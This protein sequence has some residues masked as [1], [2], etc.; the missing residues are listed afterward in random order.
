[1]QPADQENLLAGNEGRQAEGRWWNRI[2]RPRLMAEFSPILFGI[3][4]GALIVSVGTMVLIVYSIIHIMLRWISFVKFTVHRYLS[5]TTRQFYSWIDQYCPEEIAEVVEAI[6]AATSREEKMVTLRERVLAMLADAWPS[7]LIMDWKDILLLIVLGTAGL[8]FTWM[9]YGVVFSSGKRVIQRLRGIDFEAVRPGSTFSAGS[10]PAFQVQIK[11][12]GTFTDTH[13][14]FGVRIGDY[15]VTP[16]HVVEGLD[17]A[18]FATPKA[19]LLRRIVLIKS[20]IFSD[21]VFIYLGPDAVSMLGLKNAKSVQDKTFVSTFATCY[22]TQGVTAGHVSKSFSLRGMMVYRGTTVPGMSGSAYVIGGNVAGIHQGACGPVNQGFA[23]SVVEYELSKLVCPEAV[24]GASPGSDPS[25]GNGKVLRSKPAWTQKDIVSALDLAY[26]KDSTG[27][28]WSQAFDVDYNRQLDFGESASDHKKSPIIGQ[29]VHT[30]PVSVQ[31][32]GNNEIHQQVITADLFDYVMAMKQEGVLEF[33]Q[34]AKSKPTREVNETPQEVEEHPCPDCETVCRSAVKLQNHRRTAHVEKKQG[35]FPCPRCEVVCTRQDRLD[36][37]VT[38]SH[39]VKE[40]AL[41][42]DT[43][44]STVKQSG[45]FLGPKASPKSSK[46]SSRKNSP[47]RAGAGQFQSL[48]ASLKLMVQSQKSTEQL[49][50][51]LVQVSVGQGSVTM[52]N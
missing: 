8:A 24:M 11:I 42:E 29:I 14:G 48:E 30:V 20:R 18:V 45:S 23:A 27:D 47:S 31:S 22:G 51:K 15:I 4:V 10:M 34:K 1:M 36:N 35:S 38:K 49:L 13:Q 28:D 39:V 40:S 16:H 46:K 52:Q 21:L 41:P 44:A 6:K 26:T 32:P 37:H 12:P 9:L 5:S 19:K 25:M 17:S 3:R 33:V 50:Q 43:Q 7:G 2:P